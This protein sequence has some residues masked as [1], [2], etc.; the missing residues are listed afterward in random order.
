[1][2]P[3]SGSPREVQQIAVSHSIALR[4]IRYRRIYRSEDR[5]ISVVHGKPQDTTDSVRQ[6][7][8]HLWNNHKA[9]LLR[10]YGT[11]IR[12][13]PPVYLER[14]PAVRNLIRAGTGICLSRSVP[15]MV[16]HA[17]LYVPT[18]SGHSGFTYKGIGSLEG[19]P[20]IKTVY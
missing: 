13:F 9:R 2:N 4:N 5:H 18:C 10:R 20:L 1:M 19:S 11:F 17:I 8:T 6:P 14:P 12:I 16:A 7:V 3:E 15:S